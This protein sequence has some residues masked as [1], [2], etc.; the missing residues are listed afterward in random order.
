MHINEW[1][2]VAVF[3]H[4]DSS[5]DHKHCDSGGVMFLIC[6]ATSRKTF[7]WLYEFTGRNLLGHHL[8]KFEGHMYC[9]N[10]DIFLVCHL[11][12]QGHVIKVSI[13]APQG[14]SLSCQVCWS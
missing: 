11:V 9:S 6:E 10:R 8:A 13:G 12:K 4:P 5:C 3:H 2:L 7:K 1:E 14:N